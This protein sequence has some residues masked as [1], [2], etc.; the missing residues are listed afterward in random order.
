MRTFFAAAA[1]MALLTGCAKH[2]D[3]IMAARVDTLPYQSMDCAALRSKLASTETM[4]A[5]EVSAQKVAWAIDMAL[6]VVAG[7][8]NRET[9]VATL[10]GER[11]T[12]R[13]TLVAKKCS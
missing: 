9:Q 11:L 3:D 7:A 6:P 12:I 8:G 2:P 4:L 5:E 1:T 10:R 13:E